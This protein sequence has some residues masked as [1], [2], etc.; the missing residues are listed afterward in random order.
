MRIWKL[1]YA[2]TDIKKPGVPLIHVDDKQLRPVTE[3]A[4]LES[5]MWLSAGFYIIEKINYVKNFI[6]RHNVF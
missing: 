6:I 1:K 2:V 3:L 4:S 5:L